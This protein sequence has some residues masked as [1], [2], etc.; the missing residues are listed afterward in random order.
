MDSFA[1]LASE[2]IRSPKPY[3]HLRNRALNDSEWKV[4][5]RVWKRHP[6]SARD[7]LESLE[8]DT[9]WA[10]T[11]V[12]TVL[13]RLVKKGALRVRK[14]ANTSLYDPILTRGEARHS[15]LSALVDRAFG[16]TLGSLVH[17]LVDDDRLTDAERRELKRLLEKERAAKKRRK[18]P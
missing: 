11:T 9:G 15:A 5:D 6:A 4:M 16:G 13:D 17:C 8:A 7:V 12:K 1:R 18:D 10:Y 14:R 3:K 2:R